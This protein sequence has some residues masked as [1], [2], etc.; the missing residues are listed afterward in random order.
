MIILFSHFPYIFRTTSEIKEFIFPL[1]ISREFGQ[2][3]YQWGSA[4]NLIKMDSTQQQILA[5]VVALVV[6]WVLAR[7]FFSNEKSDIKTPEKVAAKPAPAVKHEQVKAAPAAP[8]AQPPK[9]VVPKPAPTAIAP[10]PVEVPVKAP[11]AAEAKKEKKPK[12]APV[13][14]VQIAA[15]APTYD[16]SDSE[17]EEEVHEVSRGSSSA[18]PKVK[19]S[20]Q[21]AFGTSSGIEAFDDDWSVVEKVGK[22]K[23][24]VKDVSPK[25]AKSGE[26]GRAHV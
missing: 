16:D 2:E 19:D 11:K 14:A 3:A 13:K 20:D 1:L 4:V 7:I 17:E 10:V 18:K 8:V 24:P 25:A 22:A 12:A 15:P 21:A 23:K 26:I 5:T 9:V 6:V